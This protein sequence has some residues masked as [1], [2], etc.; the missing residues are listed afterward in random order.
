MQYF[1]GGLAVGKVDVVDGSRFEIVKMCGVSIASLDYFNLISIRF[2]L[3][4][5]N[6]ALRCMA[7]PRLAKPALRTYV[8]Y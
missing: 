2:I 8:T 6:F 3:G 7:C 5:Y 1:A 4:E